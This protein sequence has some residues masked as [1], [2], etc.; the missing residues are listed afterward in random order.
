ML[1]RAEVYGIIDGERAYQDKS[2]DPNT[3]LSSGQTRVL[4][5]LEVAPGILMLSEYT[6]KAGQAWVNTKGSNL[7]ALQQIAKIAAIAVRVLERA[8]GSE[9]L[10]KSG[11]R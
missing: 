4:R 2:Y 11:L 8:G 1:T 3:V 5:D 7:P 10:L 6:Q 9:V